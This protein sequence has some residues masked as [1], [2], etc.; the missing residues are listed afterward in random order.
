MLKGG[1]SS[2]LVHPPPLDRPRIDDGNSTST[3]WTSCFRGE[4]YDRPNLHGEF[5]LGLVIITSQFPDI[6]SAFNID[7][8]LH[9]RC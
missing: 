3:R 4:G 2:S 6:V 8:G 9:Q 1:A 7:Q 5:H